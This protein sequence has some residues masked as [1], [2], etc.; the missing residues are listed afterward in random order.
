MPNTLNKYLESYDI[1]SAN[2]FWRVWGSSKKVVLRSEEIE[3]DEKIAKS[4]Y[5]IANYFP[6]MLEIGE[7]FAVKTL[8]SEQGLAETRL[9]GSF[10]LPTT[11]TAFFL[12]AAV[13][14]NQTIVFQAALGGEH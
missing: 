8:V 6:N 1:A 7:E 10:F 4:A 12:T 2:E 3:L 14:P 9:G 13:G 11:D 5:D